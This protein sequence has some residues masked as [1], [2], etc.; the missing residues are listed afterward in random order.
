M[1][2][3]Q[4]LFEQALTDFVCNFLEHPYD[5]YTE[6]GQHALFYADLMQRFPESERYACWQ[7]RRICVLQKE[8]PTAH[9]L[10]KPRR[11]HWDVAL[12][13]TPLESVKDAYDYLRLAAVVE[14]GLNATEEHLADD[15]E[16]LCH[17]GAN[18]E[19]RYVVHLYRLSVPGN[20]FSGRDWSAKARKLLS[21]EDVARYTV[22]NDVTAYYG[23]HDDTG[24]H[25]ARAYQITDGRI[26]DLS[27]AVRPSLVHPPASFGD[28]L[29]C[30][31]LLRAMLPFP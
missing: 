24:L 27:I 2:P 10:G 28:W 4:L 22:G 15:V 7:G 8:Y 23:M 3:S 13:K 18:L 31:V 20:R 16:R 19:R 9:D 21:T 5:A 12:L 30:P 6:H 1:S 26:T 11:Q 29:A 14:F 25:R 17:A